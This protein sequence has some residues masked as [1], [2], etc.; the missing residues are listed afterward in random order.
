MQVRL[1]LVLQE[2][3]FLILYTFRPSHFH[4]Y[5][6]NCGL[7]IVLTS[8]GIILAIFGAYLYFGIWPSHQTIAYMREPVLV[9][10]GVDM[11][12]TAT[13]GL[14]LRPELN[15]CSLLFFTAVGAIMFGLALSGVYWPMQI[16]KTLKVSYL[17]PQTKIMQRRMNNLLALQVRHVNHIL[18]Q[19][20]VK[21]QIAMSSFPTKRTTLAA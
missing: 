11:E 1:S 13:L 7:L 16:N 10:L 20:F 19:L 5:S 4:F 2:E 14:C 17:S 18:L 8:N 12:I 15:W 9:D 6:S 21:T 3:F